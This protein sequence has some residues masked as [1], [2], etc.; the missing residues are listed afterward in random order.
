MFRNSLRSQTKMAVRTII[1]QL[2]K[3]PTNRL[4]LHCWRIQPH[5]CLQLVVLYALRILSSLV[6]LFAGMGES[7]RTRGFNVPQLNLL[8]YVLTAFALAA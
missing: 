8:N 6:C 5:A 3:H 4:D 7:S 2:I 1:P